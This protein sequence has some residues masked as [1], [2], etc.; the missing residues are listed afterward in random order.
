M[1]N[2]EASAC[3]GKMVF[4]TAAEAYRYIRTKKRRANSFRAS[5]AYHCPYCHGWH[6][7]KSMYRLR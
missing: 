1:T 6:L 5:T 4:Q 7:T 3:N 2:S